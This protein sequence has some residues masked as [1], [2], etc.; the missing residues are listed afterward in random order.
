MGERVMLEG[1]PPIEILVRRS[2]RAR[3]LTL[4]V[5]RLDGRVT[6]SLPRRVPAG[7]AERFLAQKADWVRQNVARGPVAYGLAMGDVIPVE[8]IGRRIVDG[9]PGLHPGVVQVRGSRPVGA[10]VAGLLKELARDRLALACDRYAAA[11]GRPYARLTLRDTR[12]RWGSC[13]SAG[14][15]M[16]SWR[17]AMAP[18]EVLEYVAAHEVAHLVHMNHSKT[19]WR[20]VG[21]LCPDYDRHRAWLRGPGRELHAVQFVA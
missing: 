17:L 8:G 18:P 11:V 21:A 14:N 7:A 6:L 10:Q 12:S 9:R 19:F 1:D 3:R 13:T 15:L 4:R 5:S 20:Q 2:D 16:F